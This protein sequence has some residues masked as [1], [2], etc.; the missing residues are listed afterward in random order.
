[1][2]PLKA[3]AL[4]AAV[5]VFEGRTSVQ[6]LLFGHHATYCANLQKIRNDVVR[7]S[8]P[9]LVDPALYPELVETGI[10]EHLSPP[11]RSPTDTATQGPPPPPDDFALRKP[12]L[13]TQISPSLGYTQ[14]FGLTGWGYLFG[15]APPLMV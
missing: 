12:F 5:S 7:N 10:V 9:L 6:T 3:E 8:P 1:M 15:L 2:M 14:E 4:A 11:V 13:S